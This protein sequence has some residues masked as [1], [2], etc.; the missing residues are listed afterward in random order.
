MNDGKNTEVLSY[1]IDTTDFDSGMN[2]IIEALEKL[3]RREY[4]NKLQESVNGIGTGMEN[5]D[6]ASME[7]GISN[8]EASFSAMGI[9]GMTVIN[10][11]TNGIIA[12]AEK[13]VFDDLLGNAANGFAELNTQIN[14]TQTILANTSARFGTT[15]KDVNA[16]LSVLNEYADQ[17]VYNF[18]NMTQA[19]GAFTAAGVPLGDSIKA[20][21]GVANMAAYAGVSAENA[22]SG[23]YAFSNALNMGY[24]MLYQFNS[25][26]YSG[27][28]TKT[29]ENELVASG[30]ALG[31][32]MDAI[33][34]EYGSVKY[35]LESGWADQKV[36]MHTLAKFSG[37]VT[38]DELRAMKYSEEEIKRILKLGKTAI[39]AATD[40]I[41]YQKLVSSLNE[42]VGSGWA[43]TFGIVVGDFEQGKALFT[44]ISDNL[45]KV[46]QRGAEN[47]NK[48]AQDWVN[49]GGRDVVVKTIDRLLKM[50]STLLLTVGGAINQV[51]PPI[52][53]E[54][55]AKATKYLG[56]LIETL[57]PT[58]KGLENI[59]KVVRG[60]MSMV[61]IPI[62]FFKALA[63]YLW[64]IIKPMLKFKTTW[65]D[66]VV[67]F[68]EFMTKLRNEIIKGDLFFKKFTTWG[69]KV[70]EFGG[71]VQ[72]FFEDLKKT[73]AGK[74]I[75]ELLTAI[76]MKTGIKDLNFVKQF[77]IDT[78]LW[79][80]S[81]FQS[82]DK[83]K[84]IETLSK[85]ID[86]VINF[87]KRV[88]R[89]LE[90]VILYVIKL[91]TNFA[92]ALGKAFEDLANDFTW[93][94]VKEILNTI[95]KFLTIKT[96]TD[97][98]KNFGWA[99]EF[100]MTLG[101]GFAKSIGYFGT[102]LK[103]FINSNDT[104]SLLAVAVAIGILSASVF[105]LASLPK[106][107]L[108]RGIGGIT[109][110]YAGLATSLLAL[111]TIL[112]SSDTLNNMLAGSFKLALLPPVLIA[113]A[114]SVGIMADAL[115]KFKDVPFDD[116]I[117]GL[118]GIFGILT[119]MGVFMVVN[120]KFGAL[121]LSTG[122]GLI[123]LAVSLNILA[124]SL[125]LFQEIEWETIGKG[126]AVLAGL[127]V[128]VAI[129]GKVNPGPQIL[130][131]AIGLAAMAGSL[132][133]L[134]LAFKYLATIDYVTANAGLTTLIVM[135]GG[136]YLASIAAGKLSL[137]VVRNI[138]LTA[139]AIG[140]LA[141]VFT[142]LAKINATDILLVTGAIAMSIMSLHAAVSLIKPRIWVSVKGLAGL[143]AGIAAFAL[144]LLP[145]KYVDFGA[146]VKGGIA[147][148]VFIA[149]LV[150]LG[151]LASSF[152]LI[153]VGISSVVGILVAAGGAFMLFGAGVL[154]SGAGVKL[155]AEALV[156]LADA[157]GKVIDSFIA[158]IPK[159]GVAI[160]SFMLMATKTIV[161]VMPMI[162]TIGTSIV[163]AIATGV[164]AATPYIAQA[165]IS[166]FSAILDMFTVLGPKMYNT[167]AVL[168][169]TVLDDLEKNIGHYT[170]KWNRI[171][172]KF[173]DAMTETSQPL[174]DSMYNFLTVV[175]GSLADTIEEDG[176][177]LRAEI[178]R[179]SKAMLKFFVAGMFESFFVIADGLEWM[180][181]FILANGG[182]EILRKSR[183]LEELGYNV[184]RGIVRGLYNPF[185][186]AEL[187][188]AVDNI[189]EFLIDKLREALDEHS[190]SRKSFQIAQYYME[191]LVNGLDTSALQK[192]LYTV[193]DTM[194][195]FMNGALQ[196]DL[197]FQPMISPV[198]DLGAMSAIE[199]AVGSAFGGQQLAFASNGYSFRND[200]RLQQVQQYPQESVVFQQSISSAAPLS[201]EQIARRTQS[202]MA[203]SRRKS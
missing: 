78:Q 120:K 152:P 13:W 82:F 125:K 24:L 73:R 64:Q 175:T 89:F 173:I 98:L 23:M 21:K 20:V 174:V 29:L 106:E 162:N 6:F 185:S 153:V 136:L 46:I 51:F 85:F 149:A 116:V 168:L 172:T 71:K 170:A 143:S 191:G 100:L 77:L 92:T 131:V 81:L 57:M 198:L 165:L 203:Q 60:F 123:A 94:K 3:E 62:Q 181:N 124:K 161:T 35:S 37:D 121:S 31:K 17:T 59:S 189:S 16:G 104:D 65:V 117:K 66:S 163:I 25:L 159:M 34:K 148:A 99:A 164:I 45:V 40:V 127:M 72:T 97:V 87:G 91:V 50:Y 139:L 111:N 49:F 93:D 67:G 2:K 55:I 126:G 171:Q 95:M 11:I 200:P 177:K 151:A 129:I 188:K 102:A 58:K 195:D 10:N 137:L 115:I 83:N 7:R 8:V 133:L 186:L 80:V 103:Q 150:G 122:L 140:G 144:A 36:I 180:L 30:K 179:L 192:K 38:E 47:R 105:M 134:G 145:F 183:E 53:G 112:S 70:K 28:A 194:L 18:S 182:M 130:L 138:G 201:V 156:L 119:M 178:W 114:I 69:E 86:G 109:A 9:V 48:L 193:K 79:F 74:A 61:D 19:V 118:I 197:N 147:L 157:G 39:D 132:A 166:V 142:F 110:I 199:K 176:G 1:K 32:D 12:L 158:N 44:M 88:Y 90:P 135:M 184:I 54:R 101:M 187:D 15:L 33:L 52:T 27:L 75:E 42:A 5:L 108:E 26:V 107:D 96:L 202:L 68:A 167:F 84:A 141:L 56:S 76:S 41:S 155:F 22:A 169:M 113:L 154:F 146:V 160:F 14:S 128:V 43:K 4:L 190:P 63:R 196:T